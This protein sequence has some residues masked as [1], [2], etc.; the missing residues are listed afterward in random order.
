MRPADFSGTWLAHMYHILDPAWAFFSDGD[1][2][3][4]HALTA[5]HEILSAN[6]GAQNQQGT[7]PVGGAKIARGQWLGDNLYKMYRSAAAYKEAYENMMSSLLGQPYAMVDGPNEWLRASRLFRPF[8]GV[9]AF[10]TKEEAYLADKT[11][12]RLLIGSPVY[13]GPGIYDIMMENRRVESLAICSPMRSIAWDVDV[14]CDFKNER[15]SAVKLYWLDYKGTRV[16]MGTIAPG[17]T[18][19]QD[20]KM[21]HP[22][23]FTDEA[24]N[25]LRVYYPNQHEPEVSII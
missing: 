7:S 12:Q 4:S 18:R 10:F 8:P 21:T 15:E 16:G 5:I 20:T 17:A 23:L 2:E 9:D 6:V 14:S 19:H 1:A 11:Y 24:D 25:V 13:K 22:F 3:H